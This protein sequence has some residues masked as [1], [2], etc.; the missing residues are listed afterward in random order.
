MNPQKTNQFTNTDINHYEMESNVSDCPS[1]STARC[2]SAACVYNNPTVMMFCKKSY[3][4]GVWQWK[5]NF[6]PTKINLCIQISWVQTAGHP[7]WNWIYTK[8]KLT[9]QILVSI[10]PSIPSQHICID[11]SVLISSSPS[12]VY[13]FS[14]IW[15]VFPWNGVE[16]MLFEPFFPPNKLEPTGV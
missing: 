10:F 6:S 5:L 4:T 7:W 11:K 14:M 9:D 12:V 16:D 1:I 2:L 8:K 15:N 13:N 3:H